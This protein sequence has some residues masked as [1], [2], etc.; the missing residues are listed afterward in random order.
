MGMLSYLQNTSHPEILIAMRQM[1]RFSNQPML[2]HKKSI[3][4]TGR[5]LL[6]PWKH[7]IIFKLDKTKGLECYV[8]MDFAGSWLQ[9]DAKNA[10]NLVLMHANCPIL[11]VS[12]LQT[13]RRRLLSV[14]LRLSTLLC[15]NC[16]AMS[17]Y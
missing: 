17:F 9:A 6:D 12:H 14:P 16:F 1:A 7:G 11:W 10:E 5:Y 4:S 13:F 2:S 3:T 8:G 15:L